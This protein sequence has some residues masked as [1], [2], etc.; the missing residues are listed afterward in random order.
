MTVE[1]TLPTAYLA[2]HDGKGATLAEEHVAVASTRSASAAQASARSWSTPVNRST[3]ARAW[4]RPKQWEMLRTTSPAFWSRERE[5]NRVPTASSA[6]L[7][8]FTARVIRLTACA[9]RPESVGREEG[10]WVE[11]NDLEGPGVPTA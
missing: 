10:R 4:G 5:R 2:G 6:R 7:T 1:Q 3:A 9:H 8:A 11:P